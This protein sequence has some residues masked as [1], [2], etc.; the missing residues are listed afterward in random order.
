MTDF[1]T[2]LR[3]IALLLPGTEERN[4]EGKTAFTVEGAAFLRLDQAEPA[5]SVRTADGWDTVDLSTNTDWTMI[6]D[7]IARSW[8]LTAPAELLEAGGR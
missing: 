5:F 2:R 7:R 4:D 3:D 1:Q 6:E 8:E